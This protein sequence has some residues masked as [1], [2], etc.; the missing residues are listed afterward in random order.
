MTELSP[1]AQAVLNAFDGVLYDPKLRS[2]TGISAALRAAA[3]LAAPKIDPPYS[4]SYAEGMYEK[5]MYIRR[6]VLGI[7]GELD[8][9]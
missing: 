7:A 8:N 6:Q 5:Q 9:L 1:A 2:C 3:D 4:N